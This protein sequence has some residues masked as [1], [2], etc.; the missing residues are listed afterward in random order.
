MRFAALA[1]AQ[2]ATLTEAALR[3]GFATPSHF[4]AS[5]RA[6]FGAPPSILSSMDVSLCGSVAR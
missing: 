6:M 1:I 4:S 3:A 5:F 2:G